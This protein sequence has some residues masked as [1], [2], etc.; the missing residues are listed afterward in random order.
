MQCLLKN[1][2]DTQAK[3]YLKKTFWGEETKP[4]CSVP[5]DT[6]RH[7]LLA[8][9]TVELPPELPGDGLQVHEVAEAAS[10]ALPAGTTGAVTRTAPPAPRAPPRRRP[11][12][13]HFI[14][15]AAGF[16]EVG[17]GRELGVDGLPVEPAVVQV[18]HG[19]LRVLLAAELKR[20]DSALATH[21]VRSRGPSPGW[22]A[23]AEQL[24]VRRPC[25]QPGS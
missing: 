24:R 7:S 5:K 10:R 1:V 6:Q 21:P 14:L 19:L 15:A 8:P 12:L 18:D 23:A 11:H 20:G 9:A 25:L 3:S 17:H 2:N 16:P 13:P 4:Q 22:N